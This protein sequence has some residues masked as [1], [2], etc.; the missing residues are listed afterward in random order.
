MR[1]IEMFWFYLCIDTNFSPRSWWR[2]PMLE[3][4]NH[5]QQGNQGN[6]RNQGNQ[7]NQRERENKTK[8]TYLDDT[9]SGTQ[10][11]LKGS[12]SLQKRISPAAKKM[13]TTTKSHHWWTFFFLSFFLLLK[14]SSVLRRADP[15]WWWIGWRHPLEPMQLSNQPFSHAKSTMR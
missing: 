2:E 3:V 15:R 7:G 11:G 6:Q 4:K 14:S 12:N 1:R 5:W 10:P 9:G 8:T 13:T